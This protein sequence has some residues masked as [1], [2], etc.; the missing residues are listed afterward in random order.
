[1]FQTFIKTLLVFSCFLSTAHAWEWKDFKEE[2]ASPLT[3]SKYPIYAGTILA[4]GLSSMKEGISKPF[5]ETQVRHQPLGDA[6]AYG[7]LLGQL[8]PNILYVGGMALAHKSSQAM[9]M[10]KATAYSCSVTTLIKYTAR[11]PRPDNNL[12]RNSFP[13][14]HTTSAFAFSGYVAAEHGWKWGVPATLMSSFVGYSRINDNR[15]WIQDVVAGAAIG[16]SYGWGISKLGQ[17]KKSKNES[18]SAPK[19]EDIM[20]E[21][22]PEPP[23]IIPIADSETYGI[24]LYKEF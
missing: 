15:H 22:L 11:E 16:W 20:D 2:L 8:A 18:P 5:Q 24:A 10:F 3:E 21:K 4:V 19:L 17:K 1:M 9:G 7:D 14:G 6:S 13:S 12:E 23:I